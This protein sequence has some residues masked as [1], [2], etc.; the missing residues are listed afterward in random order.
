MFLLVAKL[1]SVKIDDET[2]KILLKVKYEMTLEGKKVSFSKLIRDAVTERYSTTRVEENE[3]KSEE[4]KL[5]EEIGEEFDVQKMIKEPVEPVDTHRERIV[6][7]RKEV[8]EVKT[9]ICPVCGN[10]GI[11][12]MA[13]YTGNWIHRILVK[14][15]DCG[16]EYVVSFGRDNLK[17]LNVFDRIKRRNP[18][19]KLVK[20]E[21]FL[22][23]YKIIREL[24]EA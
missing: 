6:K 18:E 13:L 24:Y 9:G 16:A 8:R 4:V 23:K 1:K 10:I 12:V 17:P 7:I 2:Y 20:Y 11:P 22:K 21:E 5:G 14:C 3:S 15:D 19:C